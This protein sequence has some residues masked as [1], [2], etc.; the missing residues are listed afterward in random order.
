MANERL[1][2]GLVRDH[3]KDDPVFSSIQWDEQ[4]SSIKLIDELLSSASKNNADTQ[5]FKKK[6]HGYPEFIISFPTNSNYLI[7]VECKALTTKHESIGRNNPI[8]IDNEKVDVKEPIAEENKNG[9]E[10]LFK[11]FMISFGTFS[12]IG[13]S[14]LQ[15]SD[16]RVM[17]K[18]QRILLKVFLSM[19]LPIF[20]SFFI[21]LCRLLPKKYIRLSLTT[22]NRL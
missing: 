9:L 5:F 11:S 8:N 2:E 21:R 17:T 12:A 13:I 3:F 10:L 7:V 15:K 18:R 16:F 19:F 22:A 4:K 14:K 6:K 20:L 1:T